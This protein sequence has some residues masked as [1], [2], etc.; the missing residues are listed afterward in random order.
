M[1]EKRCIQWSIFTYFKT[2]MERKFKLLKTW[3][4]N[5]TGLVCFS[6]LFL[7]FPERKELSVLNYTD[8]NWDVSEIS[9]KAE[10]SETQT[11]LSQHHI[12]LKEPY[13]KFACLTQITYRPIP[14]LLRFVFQSTASFFLL[15][16]FFFSLVSIHVSALWKCCRDFLFLPS[17]RTFSQLSFLSNLPLYGSA[18]MKKI[19]FKTF[20]VLCSRN[21]WRI[22]E[23]VSTKRRFVVRKLNAE[24]KQ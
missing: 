9:V 11:R 7:L 14:M 18:V 19:F 8:M 20:F 24:D 4:I 10:R 22:W 21:S 3:R 12:M 23:S 15:Y 17:Q 6:G 2:C 1:R 5:L 16:F 13:W